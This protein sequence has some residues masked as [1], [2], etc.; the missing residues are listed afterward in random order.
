L[1]GPSLFP[2]CFYA[3]T[4]S[5]IT[6]KRVM[7]S[8]SSLKYIFLMKMSPTVHI[9]E[10]MF[11]YLTREDLDVSLK[12]WLIQGESNY[13]ACAGGNSVLKNLQVGCTD[14]VLDYF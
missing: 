8:N 3:F 1:P 11:Q 7:A 10:N 2:K 5:S 13:L 4:K 12:N 6:Q 9:A 14:I